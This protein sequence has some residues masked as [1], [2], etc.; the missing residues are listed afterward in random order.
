MQWGCPFA[1]VMPHFS[2]FSSASLVVPSRCLSQAPF[3][4]AA[5]FGSLYFSTCFLSVFTFTA[6]VHESLKFVFS[7]RS[8]NSRP[9]ASFHGTGSW[10]QLS[11]WSIQ[12][13]IFENPSSVNHFSSWPLPDPTQVGSLCEP[14]L[15]DEW[16]VITAA[17][18][19][20]HEIAH[21][22]WHMVILEKCSCYLWVP[23]P[24]TD[25]PLCI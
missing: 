14:D 1:L 18:S 23:V 2:E 21:S 17:S 11:Q 15:C 16:S 24:L 7:A 12:T 10:H 6:S 8:L 22:S 3:P 5:V 20:W 19:G 9:S 25:S 13:I 4:Q